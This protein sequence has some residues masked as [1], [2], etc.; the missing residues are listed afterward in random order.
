MS[1]EKETKDYKGVRVWQLWLIGWYIYI[2]TQGTWMEAQ[3]FWDRVMFLVLSLF[4]WPVMFG[5]WLAEVLP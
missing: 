3:A 5:I 2:G 4:G 1:N